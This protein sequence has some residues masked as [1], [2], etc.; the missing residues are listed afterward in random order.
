MS[1][2]RALRVAALGVLTLG[3]AGCFTPLYGPTA[4]GERLDAVMAAIEVDDV[5]TLPVFDRL[6]HYLRSELIFDLNGSGEAVPKRYK[7]A[8]SYAQQV[9]A[10]IIDANIGRAQSATVQ[11][12]ATYTLT[13]L[14]GK[15]VTSGK[16]FGNA[17]Y[18]RSQQR[19]ATVRAARDAE[20][21][22]AKVLSEQIKARP[23]LPLA[24][25]A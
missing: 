17:T 10:P 4:S 24:T 8:I 5:E 16:A 25:R 22:L 21:R 1:W 20:I 11:G 12:E 15:L 3:V 9:T 2:L 19:F 18:D 13:T 7:L 23:S 6:G 14:D